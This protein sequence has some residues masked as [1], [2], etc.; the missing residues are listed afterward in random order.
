MGFWH[1]EAHGKR[2]RQSVGIATGQAA[3]RMFG[4]PRENAEWGSEN[5]VGNV[6]RERGT[7]E[8]VGT[9]TTLVKNASDA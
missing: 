6:R 3:S 4:I 5:N 1:G 2:Q 8:N 7:V 9:A